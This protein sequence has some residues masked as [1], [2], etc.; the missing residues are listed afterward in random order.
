[1]RS[2]RNELHES[3]VVFM[4]SR[5]TQ[6]TIVKWTNAGGQTKRAN[7]RSFV[8]RRPAWRR[9]RNVKA[10]YWTSL[11]QTLA[12]TRARLQC[13]ER[14]IIYTNTSLITNI[15]LN[16][17]KKISIYKT[18]LKALHTTAWYYVI[19]ATLTLNDRS[20]RLRILTH[21]LKNRRSFIHWV[22]VIFEVFTL[23]SACPYFNCVIAELSRARSGALWVTK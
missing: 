15:K 14:E 18:L 6:I 21:C 19:M 11:W 13:N 4:Q 20:V 10:T 7:E 12:D 23:I 3:G 22:S 16:K 8:Y 17:V 1:M 9:W 5:E 2:Q